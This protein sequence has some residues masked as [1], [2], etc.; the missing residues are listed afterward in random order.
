MQFILF[1]LALFVLGFLCGTVS[2]SAP[3]LGYFL[4]FVFFVLFTFSTAS[5]MKTYNELSR[6]ENYSDSLEHYNIEKQIENGDPV[7]ETED[8]NNA[9]NDEYP[10]EKENE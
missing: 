2:Y 7:E 10:V 3:A 1:C 5:I 4:A 9:S 8:I 6:P